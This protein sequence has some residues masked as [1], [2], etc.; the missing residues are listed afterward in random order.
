MPFDMVHGWYR[1]YRG[2]AGSIGYKCKRKGWTIWEH[3]SCPAEMQEGVRT[4]GLVHQRALNTFYIYDDLSMP[5][6][7][8]QISN[9]STVS[10]VASDSSLRVMSVPL[11]LV[12]YILEFM[13]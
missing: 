11:Y 2:F 6:M 3:A 1:A 7:E 9:T 4:M 5:G 10:S 13:V 12:Y 8:R